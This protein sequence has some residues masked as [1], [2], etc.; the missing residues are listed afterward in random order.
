MNSIKRNTIFDL[1]KPLDTSFIPY[2]NG[3]YSDPL[4]EVADWSS[5]AI[6]GF[7]VSR[8][9]LGTQTGTHIDAPAH[10]LGDGATLDALSP[11]HFVGSYFLLSL[12]L[13]VSSS[14][15][16]QLLTAYRRQKIIFLRTSEDQVSKF[17]Q[18]ALQKIVSLPSVLWVL[19]GVIVIEDSEPLEFYR[20]IA[21]A[22]KYLVEDLDQRKAHV[23]A[24]HGE[25]FVF[26]L[27]LI[28]VSGS[29][30]RV[31]VRTK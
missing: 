7:R 9:S 26:P 4:L 21:R 8:L 18:E 25:I 31:I 30:C 15:V 6:E 10:F 2:S 17:S 28:G 13:F 12:P 1:T 19:S 5:I 23:I 24:G 3:N 27:R 29:P 20:I 11:D 22:G 14:E 16:A